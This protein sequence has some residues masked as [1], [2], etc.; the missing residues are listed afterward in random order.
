MFQKK[1]QLVSVCTKIT[2]QSYICSSVDISKLSFTNNFIK[3]QKIRFNFTH[4]VYS[5][6]NHCTVMLESNLLTF[7][8]LGCI[9][10]LSTSA[11]RG[12]LLQMWRVACLWVC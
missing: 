7:A 6:T 1:S 3:P 2:N 8:L 9:A 10:A 5:K 4:V 12:L 11:R